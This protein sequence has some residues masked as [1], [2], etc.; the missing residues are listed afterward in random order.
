VVVD[1]ESNHKLCLKCTLLDELD[2]YSH[3]AQKA[4]LAYWTPEISLHHDS[5]EEDMKEKKNPSAC[6]TC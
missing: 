4:W 5:I 6:S 1:V 3:V 2:H